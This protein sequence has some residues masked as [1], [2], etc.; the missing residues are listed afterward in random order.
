V[1]IRE[2]DSEILL[3]GPNVFVGY[4]ND[5]ASTAAAFDSE[6][7][8]RTGDIGALD[9]DGFLRITGRKKEVIVTAGGKNVVP[10]PIEERIRTHPLISQAVV[11]G[12]K[13]RFVAALITL[14]EEAVTRWATGQ[15]RA[16]GQDTP[17]VLR[18]DPALR[19]EVQHAIDDANA[20][21]SR[22]ESV[23]EFVILPEDFTEAGGT[24]TPS[25]K[26]KRNVVVERYAADI[27]RMYA[28]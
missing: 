12:D 27:A 2:E 7:W 21:I 1:R 9:D 25:L 17:G 10:G 26:I 15:G 24:L 19:A 8:F 22:A 14:D 16:A 6:G 20:P 4:W 11:I 28:T 13:E 23:R 3:R 18:D 5:E